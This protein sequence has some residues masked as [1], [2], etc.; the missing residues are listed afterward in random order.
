MIQFV[1]LHVWHFTNQAQGDGRR[2][3]STNFT[4]TLILSILFNTNTKYCG[5]LNKILNTKAF[6]IE[7][8]LGTV[9]SL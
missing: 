5:F 9:W 2:F 1:M 7:I 4:Q 6:A 3:I 8:T